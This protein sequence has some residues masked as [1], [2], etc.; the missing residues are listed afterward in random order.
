MGRI[1]VRRKALGTFWLTIRG[2]SVFVNT[3][4]TGLVN[5]P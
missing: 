4:L 1:A 5:Q 2:A 3:F